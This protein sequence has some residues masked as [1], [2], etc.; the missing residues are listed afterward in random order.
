MLSPQQ[1]S[2]QNQLSSSILPSSSPVSLSMIE[3]TPLCLSCL[4]HQKPY[5]FRS[6]WSAKSQKQSSSYKDTYLLDESFHLLYCKPQ[7]SLRFTPSILTDSQ[8][9]VFSNLLFRLLCESQSSLNL[10][11]SDRRVF[12]SKLATMHGFIRDHAH[13]QLSE[14][15]HTIFLVWLYVQQRETKLTPRSLGTFFLCA[16]MLSI[17]VS[18]D[19]PLNNAWWAYSFNIP[20]KLVNES[21]ISFLK[22]IGYQTNMPL[23]MYEKLRA[24]F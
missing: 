14:A 9:H 17:K 6:P 13:L 21:E 7:L 4:S 24:F 10:V 18:R 11:P 19:V 15:I 5:S 3:D 16:T 12:V 20:N 22:T 8:I 2:Q 23:A 1:L